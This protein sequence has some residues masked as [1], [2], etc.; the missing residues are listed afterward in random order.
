MDTLSEFPHAGRYWVAY[1]GGADSTALL[2]ALH[3]LDG[4]L[5]APLAAVHVNHGLHPDCDAWQE[6]CEHFCKTLGIDLE[7]QT[8]RPKRNAGSGMEAEARRLR[9]GV[10]QTLL[11][12]G[13][14]LLTAHHSDDQAET[15]L[16]N[17][18]RGSG[19]DGLAGMPRL[20][21]LGDGWL[22]RPLLGFR[23]QSLRAYL[24]EHAMDWI[25]DDSNLDETYDR[26]YLRKR[27]IPLLEDRWHRA[28]EKI[29]QSSSHCREAREL[30]GTVADAYLAAHLPHPQV[31]DCGALAADDPAL[32]K[33]VL[34]RWLSCRG[35]ASLPARRLEELIR[36]V[37]AATAEHHIRVEWD[38]WLLHFYRQ[39]LWLQHA[40]SIEP[41][42]T[43][44]WD[45]P[46]PLDLGP[47]I[48]ELTIGSRRKA[49]ADGLCV[50]ARKAGATISTAA[51]GHKSIKQLL[52]ENRVPPWLR[53]SVPMLWMRG[54][55]VALGDWVV[56]PRLRDWLNRQGADIRWSPRDPVLRFVRERCQPDAVD[57]PPPLG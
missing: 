27:L 44:A 33:T 9:Y 35:A 36:Q 45:R 20:R 7:C 3:A 38:A 37:A 24:S 8:V 4:R 17:L 42:P 34:R 46:A 43:A 47:V 12:P 40:A 57:H 5:G 13:E 30:L 29:A 56:A 15:V 14:M 32:F 48:G 21:R 51:Q 23:G 39:R 55:V 50:T 1:S 54:E 31:L 49:P 18:L 28:A 41:C 25:E 19:V 10:A 11:A 2:H 22:A 53:A 6:R 16:L 52:Q 26:N